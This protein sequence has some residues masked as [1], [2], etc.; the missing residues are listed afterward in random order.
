[1]TLDCLTAPV[2]VLRDKHGIPHIYA[3][4]Q[5]DLLRAQGFVH[6][7]D[8]LWQMEQNR[9]I[10]H[11][12]LA[13]FFGQA[14]LDVD[15]FS[16]IVGFRRAAE[17]ELAT[18]E[19]DVLQALEH[20][21][22]GVNAYIRSRPGRLAP[23]FN[24]LRR[25]PAP[26]TPLDVV[27]FS[28]VMAWS[29]CVNWESELVRLQ[30]AGRF[31]PVR[32]ADLEP[33]YPNV[34]PVIIEGVGST[35]CMR[36]VNTAG[37]LLNQYDQ[38]RTWLNPSG[39]NQGSNCWAVVPH[40]SASGRA[41]LCND[42][43]LSLRM[44]GVWYENHLHCPELH[45][46]GA[47]F[48]GAPGVVIGHNERIAWGLTNAFADVQDL[49]LERPHPEEPTRFEYEGEWEPA[50]VLREKINVRG[51]SAPHEEEVI[52]TRHGPLINR[53]LPEPGTTP[54][55]LRWQGH[56][57][58]RLLGAILA[59]NKARN[60]QEFDA[61]LAG[62]SA[63]PQNVVYADVDGNIGYRLAG[64]IPIR[65]DGLGLVPA[66]GWTGDH[67]WVGVIPDEDLPRLFN[68]PSGLIVTAN[69]KMA[70][71]DYPHF[72]GVE[73]FPG[74]RARRIEE[75]LKAKRHL[76]LRDMEQIQLDVTSLYAQA[77]TPLLTIQH[78]DDPFVTIALNMLRNWSYGMEAGSG[79]ALVFQYTLLHLLEMTFGDKLGPAKRGFL[80]GTISPLFIM[81]GFMHRAETR[82]LELLKGED[83]SPWY[84][85][86]ASGRQRTRDELIA[87][88]LAMAVKRIRREVNATP[89]HWAWG[90]M[91]QVRYMHPMGSVPLLKGFFNRGPFPVGGDGTTPNQTG[92]APELP[93]GLVQI[94]ASYRQIYDVGAWD[95]AETVTTNG[96]SGHPLSPNYTDQIA[97]WL[98][99]VYH[100]MPWSRQAVDAITTRRLVLNSD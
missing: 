53:L 23:E 26:W 1:M 65:A 28:K 69:N 93:P 39:A 44:P 81:S 38:L 92:Y 61:A 18:L 49:Y 90:R 56:E 85:D 82:L 10:G 78:S 4:N 67:E 57:P 35:E 37:L 20:Y 86:A 2:T 68:P 77:L 89:R 25:Q 80:G 5:A 9:R 30:L 27:A 70:G 74:W 75:M 11:G 52:I 51:R 36:M 58:G 3:E 41:L 17:A 31:D 100:P 42:P 40:R 12:T 22:E 71:D 55:A 7:Q 16:R 59:L 14:A 48:A 84:M 98:E 91:H 72:L 63:P 21:A 34:N 45:V 73:T 62:W 60:W 97:M 29:L 8:R 15:R 66:P 76:S 64:H 47:S 24:L 94:V 88:A 32:A 13:E 46:S 19:P 6:A 99:G 50:Q 54:L 79:A 33:D 83:A 95:L 87:E 96:Q 43:H